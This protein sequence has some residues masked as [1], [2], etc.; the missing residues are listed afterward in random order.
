MQI[1]R[2]MY[3]PEGQFAALASAQMVPFALLILATGIAL[4]MPNI[5]ELLNVEHK[6]GPDWFDRRRRQLPQS[7]LAAIAL[8]CLAVYII[9]RLDSFSEFLYFQFQ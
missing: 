3:S 5:K 1:Y 4:L 2:A 9:T 8:A 6:V 7:R